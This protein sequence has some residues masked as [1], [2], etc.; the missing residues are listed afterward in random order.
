MWIVTRHPYI[1]AV[2]V[3]LALGVIAILIRFVVRSLRT[4]LS[5]AEAALVQAGTGNSAR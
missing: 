4:L 3:L 1:A 2:I 5:D